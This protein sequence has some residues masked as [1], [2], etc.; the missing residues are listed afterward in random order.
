M[1][2]CKKK[3]L[4][5]EQIRFII[6]KA[7][8]DYFDGKIEEINLLGGEPTIHPEFEKI[9]D[10]FFE[11][12][13]KIGI[14]TNGYFI[15][16]IN[17]STL[18]KINYIQLSC[19]CLNKGMLDSYRGNGYYDNLISVTE[20]LKQNNIP[21]GY[22]FLVAKDTIP[23]LEET[24]SLAKQLGASK[25][26]GA[27]FIPMGN[28]INNSKNDLSKEDL[29]E[30]YTRV[31]N[32]MIRNNIFVKISDGLWY[33]FL[34][35]QFQQKLNFKGC[36]VLNGAIN[37]IANGDILL[38]RKIDYAFGNILEN[39]NAFN[40]IKQNPLYIQLRNRELMGKCG[41]CKNKAICGGCRAYAYVKCNNLLAQDELCFIN[42]YKI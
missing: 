32:A 35:N 26:S 1:E 8:S 40:L 2:D 12:N 6:Q 33:S 27:R 25:I 42:N 37:V 5:F 39:P 14:S 7:E 9:V 28:G 31:F 23:Y 3:Q 16:K 22:K 24:I 41:S 30:A 38:C 34:Q 4:T 10:Y 15:K 19:E 21:Y 11:N 36:A 29:I 13:Y 18:K 17:L 20:Y